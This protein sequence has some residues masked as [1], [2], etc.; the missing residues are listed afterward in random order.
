[1]DTARIVAEILKGYAMS[2]WGFHGVAHWARVLEN[3]LR[4]ADHTGA[5][6]DVLTLFALFHDSRRIDDG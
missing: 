2:P 3:G 4:L 6:R 1:M 5:D